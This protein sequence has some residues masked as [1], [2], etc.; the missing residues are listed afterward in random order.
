MF[1]ISVKTIAYISFCVSLHPSKKFFIL[2]L[3][4]YTTSRNCDTTTSFR[5]VGTIEGWRDRSLLPTGNYVL[6]RSPTS[7]SSPSKTT[8]S[9]KGIKD[10]ATLLPACCASLCQFSQTLTGCLFYQKI[11]QL[12]TWKFNVVQK[13]CGV[14]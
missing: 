3:L 5:S 11:P 14:I 2:Y 12:E 1:N 13:L 9:N 10:V 6:S 4:I 7:F 8:D